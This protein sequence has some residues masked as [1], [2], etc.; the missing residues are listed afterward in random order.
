MGVWTESHELR[1]RIASMRRSTCAAAREA[2]ALARA[3][4]R[5]YVPFP[6]GLDLSFESEPR[7]EQWTEDTFWYFQGNRFV[8]FREMEQIR[9]EYF[10]RQARRLGGD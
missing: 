4:E 8:S 3:A 2:E 6:L 1:A 7:F 9:D 5:V 10:A